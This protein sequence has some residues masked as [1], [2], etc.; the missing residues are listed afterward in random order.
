[1]FAFESLF[2]QQQREKCT[3]NNNARRK[4][5]RQA[6]WEIERESERKQEHP[7]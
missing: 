7:Q 5:G 4:E 6:G 1:V 3:N 2:L